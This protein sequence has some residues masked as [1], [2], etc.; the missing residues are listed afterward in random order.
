MYNRTDN[1]RGAVYIL[2]GWD[3]STHTFARTIPY[4]N[5]LRN[6]NN[7]AFYTD[8][9]THQSWLY[10]PAHRQA[11]PLRILSRRQCPPTPHPR[12]SPT[13]PTTASTTSTGGWHLTRTIAFATLHGRTKLFVSVGSSCNACTEKEPVRATLQIM[14][15]DGKHHGTVAKGL[16]NAVGLSFISGVDGG[17]L[18]ATNMGADHLGDHD[19]EDQFFELDSNDHP[20]PI[21]QAVRFNFTNWLEQPIPGSPLSARGSNE[22]TP[23]PANYGWPTCSTS[24]TARPTPTSS[25]LLPSPPTT[26][27]RLRLKDHHHLS[28]TAPKSL[29]HTLP[30]HPTALPSA[31]NTSTPPP[32]LRPCATRFW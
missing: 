3:E 5:H 1:T 15:P 24:T 18:F 2:D 12:S 19:P 29:P 6:P 13:I 11:R 10:N 16:R 8:P 28:S 31:S 32:Q 21:A 17:S 9:T 23:I 22:F 25:S 27:S 30:S 26:S 7:L 20:G 14:D 4:L